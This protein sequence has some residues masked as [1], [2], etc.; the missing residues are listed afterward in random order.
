MKPDAEVPRPRPD[1]PDCGGNGLLFG[2]DKGKARAMVCGCGGICPR[3]ED[4]GR[5]LLVQDGVR[6]VAR[7]LCRLPHDRC[8]HFNGAGLPGRHSQSSFASFDQQ[9]PGARMG[10]LNV[11][12]W[13]NANQA[14]GLILFGEVGRG[15]TH[16]L[17]AA[18]RT[19]IFDKGLRARFVEFSLLLAD[20]K[21]GWESGRGTSSLIAEALDT[22]I[23][24]IDELGKGRSTEWELTVLD[25]LV[26][27]AYNDQKILVATTNYRPGEAT[28]AG[29]G[30]LALVGTEG[31]TP[32]TLGDRV[33]NRVYSRLC[34]MCD[35]VEIGRGGI[36]YRQLQARGPHR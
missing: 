11:R 2:V 25:E 1:C 26:S 5:L 30:N 23:L 6:R 15:K 29:P 16:L 7:C 21:R 33:G 19:L 24:A 10:F 18:L 8:D 36:D 9:A 35:F 31:Q 13:A 14:R 3:C 32:Q 20:I 22:D 12:G 28:G 4:S 17:A 34:E 27:R